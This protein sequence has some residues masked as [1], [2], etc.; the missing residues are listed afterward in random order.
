MDNG[1]S[2]QD[3]KQNTNQ[4]EQPDD[5]PEY[6]QYLDP[7]YH[8]KQKKKKTLLITGSIAA[9]LVVITIVSIVAFSL[10][11]DKKDNGNQTPAVNVVEACDSYECFNKNFN[12]CLPA[13]YEESEGASTAKY[14]VLG[15]KKIGCMTSLKYTKNEDKNL[16]GKQMTCDFDNELDFYTAA[17][18][19]FNY[20]EDYECEGDLAE[21]LLNS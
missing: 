17:E 7:D 3:Q 20:L 13:I 14:E 21:Y 10:S 9:A 2:P 12:L 1:Q 11:S 15:I 19:V 16:F 5:G 8:K 6:K 4:P 18:L